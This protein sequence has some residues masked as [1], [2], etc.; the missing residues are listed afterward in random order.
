[1]PDMNR[2]MP[3]IGAQ[4][5]AIRQ[6]AKLKQE[7]LAALLRISQASVSHIE[8]GGVTTTDVMERW[9]SACSAQALISSGFDVEIEAAVADMSETDK[10]RL[11]RIARALPRA[12]EAAKSGMT[13]AFEELAKG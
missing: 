2:T 5:R 1:M 9:A 10:A 6:Q 7:E 4:L 12:A 3:S 8:N 13:L 11:L